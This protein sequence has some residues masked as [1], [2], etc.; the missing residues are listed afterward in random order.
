[1][2]NVAVFASGSGTNF[3]NLVKQKYKHTNICVL[4]VDKEQAY[5][6]Q[7]AKQLQIPCLYFNPKQ[8]DSKANYEMAILKSLKEYK[9]DL[10]VLSGYMRFIGSV[11]LEAFTNRIINLH[12]AYLPEF[13]GAHS[14]VEAYEANVT[15]SGV[16]IHYVDAGI[17]TGKIIY[18]EKLYL[19]NTWTLEQFEAAIHQLEY[20][21]FPQIVEVVSSEVENE[22]K[23]IN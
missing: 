20:K 10:I 2:V 18:Q 22:K 16:T 1:M 6:I 19:D 21:L 8:Y 23:S 11:L 15:Y 9:I 13:P 7:R 17:D 4:I 14:I 5:A 3:E 12:P